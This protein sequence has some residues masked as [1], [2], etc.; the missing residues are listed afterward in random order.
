MHGR[1]DQLDQAAGAFL[2]AGVGD[3]Q[4]VAGL[5]RALVDA[6]EAELAAGH[7]HDLEDQGAQRRLGIR[8]GRNGHA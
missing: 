2:L 1:A 7:V 3:H 4:L 6:H 5:D 8:L